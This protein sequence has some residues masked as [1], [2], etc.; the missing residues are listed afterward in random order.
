MAVVSGAIWPL[1][2]DVFKFGAGSAGTWNAI[3]RWLYTGLTWTRLGMLA[4]EVIE[5]LSTRGYR[6]EAQAETNRSTREAFGGY[7]REAQAETEEV[8]M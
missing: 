8:P 1:P 3:R 6:W 7:S 5:L 4:E 2:V